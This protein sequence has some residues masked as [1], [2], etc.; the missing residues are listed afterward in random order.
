MCAFLI[1]VHCKLAVANKIMDK[2]Q[3]SDFID[4]ALNQ[5]IC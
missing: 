3:L 1:I 4:V 2:S 5:L